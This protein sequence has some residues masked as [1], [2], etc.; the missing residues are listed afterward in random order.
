MKV[1]AEQMA[2]AL[3][4]ASLDDLGRLVEEHWAHQRTLHPGITTP[5]I[6]AIVER[7]RAAGALGTKALGAS[8]GGCV[9]VVAPEGGPE[10]V[11]EAIGDLSELLPYT[12]D[13]TGLRVAGGQQGFAGEG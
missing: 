13:R 4:R 10:R 6:D 9:L 2:D 8:G 3:R 11:R 1:L 5:R 12:V 7:A